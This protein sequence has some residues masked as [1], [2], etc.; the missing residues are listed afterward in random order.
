MYSL[1]ES[2]VWRVRLTPSVRLYSLYESP[3]WRVRLT[4]SVRLY[5]LYESPVC[6]NGFVEP[7]EQCDCGLPDDCKNPCCDASSC[8]LKE[9]AVCA[10]GQCCD[11]SVSSVAG[12][13]DKTGGLGRAEVQYGLVGCGLGMALVVLVTGEY[14]L[15]AALGHRSRPSSGL[16][17]FLRVTGQCHCRTAEEI[18][19]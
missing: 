6:G 4:P 1:Y 9:D 16:W 17:E 18:A 15:A 10:T 14:V 12:Y 7:G 11:L 2:P 13:R 3:V 5:S 19:V 8:M